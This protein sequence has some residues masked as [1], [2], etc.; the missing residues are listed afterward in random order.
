MS[1]YDACMV[2][3]FIWDEDRVTERAFVTRAFYCGEAVA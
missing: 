1:H 2:I 3:P